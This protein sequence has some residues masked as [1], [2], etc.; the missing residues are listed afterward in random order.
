[1][2]YN[3]SLAKRIRTELV[4]IP[5]LQVKK[6]FGGVAYL[7]RGNMA[8]GVYGND[9]LIRVGTKKYDE[10]LHR[11]HT[12]P[13][14]TTGRPMSGWIMIEPEGYRSSRDFKAWIEE[15]LGFANSLKPK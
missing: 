5:D 1:M 2:P 12:R 13:F 14:E 4:Q 7:V 6:M 15:G 11:P 10:A 8:C 9:L 3:Q